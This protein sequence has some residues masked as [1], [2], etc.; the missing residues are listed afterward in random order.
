MTPSPPPLSR[1]EWKVMNVCWR[2]GKATA[3]QVRE[4]SDELGRREYITVKTM[5]DRIAQKGYL[6]VEKLGP[7]RLY[8][9][10]I[11]KTRALAAAVREFKDTVLDGALTPLFLYLDGAGSL[12]EEEIEELRNL[13]ERHK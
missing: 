9:P 1:L 3:R 8:T 11:R 12:T 6:R 7:L 10:R 13:L 4:A 5:L 2:L